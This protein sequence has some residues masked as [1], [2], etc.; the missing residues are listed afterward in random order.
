MELNKYLPVHVLAELGEHTA[1]R[2]DRGQL[3]GEA[4]HTA[5]RTRLETATDQPRLSR[6]ENQIVMASAQEAFDRLR[7]I[8]NPKTSN[9]P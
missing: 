1:A 2:V 4:L 7:R 5:R 8:S 9:S 3:V 6:F